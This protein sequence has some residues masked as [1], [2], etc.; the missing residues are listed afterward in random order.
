[1][2][3]DLHKSPDFARRIHE[4]LLSDDPVAPTELTQ[5]FLEPLLRYL[6]AAHPEVRDDTLLWDAATDAILNYAEE[7]TT[8]DPSKRGLYGYLKMS[9]NG[10]LLNAL[11][12]ETRRRRRERPDLRAVE[13]EAEGGKE[14][15]NDEDTGH[16]VQRSELD[17][18]RA[19]ETMDRIYEALP[20]PKDQRMLQLMLDGVRET[21]AYARVLEIQDLEETQ[22]RKMVKRNKDRIKVRIKRLDLD[23]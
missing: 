19:R 20:D 23:V 18:K 22:K 3:D 12:K 10:D 13:L 8:F 6:Q 14:L 11:N 4:R 16:L 9:A 7:P 21:E 17:E 1:M 2:S 15:E 5:V